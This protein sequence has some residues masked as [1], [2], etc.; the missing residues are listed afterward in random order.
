MSNDNTQDTKALLAAGAASVNAI[1]RT[2]NVTVEHDGIAV[3][4]P[5]AFDAAGNPKLLTGAYEAVKA[6]AARLRPQRANSYAFSDLA[7]LILWAGRYKTE[8]SAVYVDGP[9]PGGDPGSVVVV[10]D[11][12]PAEGDIGAHRA[13]QARV[14]IDLSK[15]LKEWINAAGSWMN[16]ETFHSF[17]D[18][19]SDQLASAEALTMAMNVEIRSESTWKRTVDAD[20]G[21]VKL[22]DESS[23]GP[24]AAVPRSFAFNVPVFTFHAVDDAQRFEA[25]L[26]MKVDRGKPYFK[27]ELKQLERAISDAM[28]AIAAEMAKTVP[29]VYMGSGE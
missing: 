4:L 2:F 5:H 23:S 6:E 27:I 11:E 10:V 7:S 29:V 21:R 24:T 25:R 12:F 18:E 20:T 9:E 19:R 3:T 15:E 16:A 14:G 8:D 17:L 28:T 1:E 26:A 22:V 13:L